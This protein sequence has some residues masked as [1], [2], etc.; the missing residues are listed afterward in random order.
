MP[1]RDQSPGTDGRE[2]RP[3]FAA[4]PRDPA[5]FALS[6]RSNFERRVA[7]RIEREAVET[8]V[9]TYPE[10]TLWSDRQKIVDRLIL[11]GYVLIRTSARQAI[12]I[13][14]STPGVVD[15]LGFPNEPSAIP[16]DEISQFRRVVSSQSRIEPCAYVAGEAI[17]IESGPLAG[18]TGVVTRTRGALR[19]VVAIEL[20]NRAVSVEVDAA[21]LRRTDGPTE[22]RVE[23]ARV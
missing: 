13:A 17:A 4:L 1:Q 22:S 6:V 20:L 15:I 2:A 8:F 14:A 19:V 7:E 10:R 9:P 3:S 12:T 23:P 21:D 18:V 11:P 5:W 16:D